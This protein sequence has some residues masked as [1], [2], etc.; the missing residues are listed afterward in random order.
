MMKHILTTLLIIVAF[1]GGFVFEGLI[2]R[3][4]PDAS[5]RGRLMQLKLYVIAQLRLKS[6]IMGP[7]ENLKR[8]DLC[9]NLLMDG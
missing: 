9:T 6:S 2:T 5:T 1:I 7:M 8:H 3:V 4:P